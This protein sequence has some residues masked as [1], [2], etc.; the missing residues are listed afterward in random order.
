MISFQLTHTLPSLKVM[1]GKL[2]GTIENTESKKQPF[3]SHAVVVRLVGSSEPQFSRL[4]NG[5]IS[6][7]MRVV[8]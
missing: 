7:V 5:V 1:N 4:Q 6:I 8:L 2:E 3:P